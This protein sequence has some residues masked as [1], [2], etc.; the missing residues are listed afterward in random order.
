MTP[1]ELLRP[2]SIAEAASLLD[3]DDPQVRAFAGGTAL[4][5]MMKA[6]FLTPTGLISL[7]N[8]EK[9]Y[10]SFGFG[11][12]GALRIGAM[13]RLRAL[14][15]SAELRS[16]FPVVVDALRVLANV[17]VRNVATVGGA[18]AHGDPHMDLPPVLIALGAHVSTVS[19]EGSRDI[20]VEDLL[21]GYYETALAS[22]ELIAEI[23]VPGQGGRRS[24]YVKCTTRSADDWPALGVAVSF[25]SAAGKI[26]APRIVVSAATDRA[27]R[28]RQAEAVLDAAEPTSRAFK[29]AAETAADE[30]DVFSDVRGSAPYKRQ[31]IRV[32]V[33]RA[34]QKAVAGSDGGR[35]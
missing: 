3:P 8:I 18:V 19:P 17:R 2:T 4:M 15:L 30:A 12:D 6:G 32:H 33:E 28:L 1:F 34:L 9:R 25:A 29:E 14:E 7:L 24:A 26:A 21:V 16:S 20:A 11:P 23:S 27:V 13:T 5:L 22:T 35:S 10:A 31:L